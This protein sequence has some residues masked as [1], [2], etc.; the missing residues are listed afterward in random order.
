MKHRS[1]LWFI[2]SILLAALAGVLA[3]VALNWASLQETAEM[4]VFKQTVVV[5]RQPMAANSFI[6][7][8]NITVEE[9]QEIPSGAA[10]Q[11]QDVLG[12][13]TLR[14]IAQGEVIRMQDLRSVGLT[15]GITG[16]RNLPMLLG[17]NKIAVALPADD[18][19]SQWGAVLPGDHVDVL[20]TLDV[21]LETPMDLEDFAGTA[22]EALIFEAVERDQ[23]LDNISVLTLQNLEV[24]QI[25]EEP[26]PEDQFL[27]QEEGVPLVPRR[28]LVLKVDPQDAVVLKYLRD[29]VGTVDLALR[30]PT[31][32]ALFNV[33]P[34]NINYLVLR[35]GIVLPQPLE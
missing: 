33:Q 30:S 4:P 23:S 2:A 24:L 7:A 26:L 29:S 32:N 20:F 14:D 3:I 27:Q 18:I 25:L 13:M 17:D 5:A 12:R 16:T 9:R 28:A 19:L 21:I 22:E 34:V 31:N 35:Y 15:T 1:W 6:R 10:V 11:A 8:D